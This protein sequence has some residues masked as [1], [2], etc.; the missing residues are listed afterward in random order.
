MPVSKQIILGCLLLTL[1]I[2]YFAWRVKQGNDKVAEVDGRAVT[3]AELDRAGGKPLAD[4]RLQ[5]YRAE[6]QKIDELII[7]KLLSSEAQKKGISSA[8]LLEQE[9]E[10]K[11][12]AVTKEEIEALYN[13]NKERIPVELEKVRDKIADFVKNQKTETAKSQYLKRLKERAK[14][15][16]YLKPPP[17]YRVH[18]P[19]QGSP[20]KGGENATVTVVKFEDFQCPFCKQV[21]PTLAEL[22]KRYDGKVKLVHRDLPLDSIHP[23][24]RQAAEAA[25]CAG[26]Q[27][28]FWEYHDVLYANSTK[29]SLEDL[30]G[31]ADELGLN[32]PSFLSCY[33]GGKFKAAVQNDFE[34]GSRLGITGTPTFFINGRQISGALP[35][36]SFAAVIDEELG[37]TN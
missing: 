28:K 5:L 8:T 3:R 27:G 25:R 11:I 31:Y 9:V 2:F 36:E 21:Q 33:N 13:N 6:Q 17:I 35:V 30:K 7:E 29:L 4:L 16:T 15:A 34:V 24:A 22:L 12:P 32:S 19:M 37:Q 10:S 14:I 26:E 23:L 18:V 1:A 20:F